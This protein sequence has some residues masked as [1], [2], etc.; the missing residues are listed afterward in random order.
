SLPQDLKLCKPTP[1][2]D[3][4]TPTPRQIL[5]V[6][7]HISL[8]VADSSRS[9]CLTNPVGGPA[10]SDHSKAPK[11]GLDSRRRARSP[12]RLSILESG[13][14]LA[15]VPWRSPTPPLRRM[16]LTCP[17][18]KKPSL[19]VAGVNLQVLHKLK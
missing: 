3:T 18:L 5:A 6:Y 14:V 10:I 13:R 15:G 4:P 9:A 8:P 19:V 17:S 2:P 16:V 1:Y 11:P 7:P 12:F